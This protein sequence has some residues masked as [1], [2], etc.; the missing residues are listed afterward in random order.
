MEHSFNV[1]GMRLVAKTHYSII[2]FKIANDTTCQ[3]ENSFTA[4][5]AK[6]NVDLTIVANQL[7]DTMHHIADSQRVENIVLIH[8]SPMQIVDDQSVTQICFFDH[9]GFHLVALWSVIDWDVVEA[10]LLSE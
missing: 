5:L 6:S 9:Q 3:L 2:I 10:R 7:N 1:V 4:L 8:H